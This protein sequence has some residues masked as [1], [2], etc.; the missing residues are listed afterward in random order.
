M[1]VP[2]ILKEQQERE[3]NKKKDEQSNDEQNWRDQID[4]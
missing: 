3:Q 2:S 1:S 4:D